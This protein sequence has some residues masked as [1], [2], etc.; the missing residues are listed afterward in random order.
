MNIN[1]L[2]F[3][4]YPEY[5]IECYSIGWKTG[6]TIMGHR[7]VEREV[8]RG[9]PPRALGWKGVLSANK[10]TYKIKFKKMKTV[11]NVLPC[12]TFS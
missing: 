5:N 7:G 9:K 3:F 4:T 2:I 11:I 1:F 10:K 8:C 6:L 12:V